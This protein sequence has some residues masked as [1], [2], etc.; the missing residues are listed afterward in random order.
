MVSELRVL[1]VEDEPL[2]AELCEHELRGAGFAFLSQRVYTR[3][4]YTEALTSFAPDVILSDFS[5]PTDLDGFAA[6]AIAREHASDIPFVFVSGT[7]GEERAVEAMKAGATDYVLKDRLNRLGPVVRRALQEARDRRSMRSAQDALRSSETRFRYFMQHLPAR[8]SI[9]DKEGH[10]TYVNE[11]WEQAVGLT[12][13]EVVGRLYS[14]VWDAAR[15]A[16]IRALQ[17]E[18]MQTNQPVRRVIR[19]GDGEQTKWWLSHQFPIP[20]PDGTPAMVG[21]IGLDVTEQKLQDEKIERLNRIHAVLSGINSAIV[22]IHDTEKLLYEACRIAVDAG[23]FGMAWIG[24]ADRETGNFKAMASAGLLEGEETSASAL[25]VNGK[26]RA[27]GR[28]ARMLESG[29]PTVYNDITRHADPSRHVQEAIRRGYRSVVIL[30]LKVGGQVAG[31]F[32]LYATE[33]NFFTHGELK[34]LLELAADVSFAL[35]YID[36][37]QKLYYLAWHDP[38]T[39][40]A[41]RTMLR[42]HLDRAIVGAPRNGCGIA[43]LV[44]D[45]KRFRGINDT[46]GRD[47][48]D[49]L[50]RQIATRV[51]EDWPRLAEA[52]RLSADYFG[53]FVIDAQPSD[54]AHM[55]TQSGTSLARPFKVGDHELRVDISVGI[56]FFPVDGRSADSLLANAEAAL[57]QAKLRGEQYL[58]YEPAMNARVAEKLSLENKMRRALE[59]N[60]FVLHYQPKIHLRTSRV[61]GVEALIRWQ[62]PDS[63]LIGPEH[64]VPLLEETGLILEVGRWALEKALDDWR[65]RAATGLPTPRVAVN[66]SSTQLRRADFVETVGSALGALRGAEH[67]LELEITETMLM[68]SIGENS[69]K[70][71]RLR[72]MGVHFAIDDF[73]TGYSSLSY[74]AKLPVDSLKIDRTFITTMSEEPQSLTIVSTIISLA[75]A[76]DLSVVAE[77]VETPEQWTML[78]ELGCDEIQ[79]YAYSRPVPWEECLK[80]CAAARV[81]NQ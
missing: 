32:T 25:I 72:G 71:Q 27:N 31:S 57:K 62:D 74:L 2:D 18:V 59:R 46:F 64:F 39:G 34:L 30:P 13:Q 47:V 63:G 52:A 8:A 37:E 80:L 29:K 73:G 66:V 24:M 19:R 3:A 10:Y 23:E 42:D 36:T 50:L 5:M 20:G 51:R 75:H 44:W 67:G 15:S 65:A 38:V 81:E 45:V 28:V 17:D 21:T 48:G 43:V 9:R 6:L 53:G 79:G 70:L 49:E 33:P 56:S 4:A 16:E 22:R 54:I 58:F 40:I 35:E 68:D 76:L 14:D 7:I 41:N 69:L 77:G 61:G 55:I 78:R 26:P 60:E 12:A 11:V 1:L